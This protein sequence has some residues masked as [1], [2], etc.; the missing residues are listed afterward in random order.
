[1]L[2]QIYEVSC[3]LLLYFTARQISVKQS[4]LSTD[5]K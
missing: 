5:L 1:M 4:V 3:F 2:K